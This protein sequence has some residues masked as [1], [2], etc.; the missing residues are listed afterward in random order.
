MWKNSIIFPNG[1]E[2]YAKLG[3]LTSPFVLFTLK[4]SVAM[5]IYRRQM[6]KTT[7]LQVMTNQEFKVAF[8]KIVCQMLCCPRTGWRDNS[9]H[10]D[11]AR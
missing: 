7:I 9:E 2:M 1:Y 3:L 4:P 8:T 6:I 11:F 5:N 10:Y